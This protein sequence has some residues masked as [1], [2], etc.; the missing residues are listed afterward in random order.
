[1]LSV[2]DLF[3]AI[4]DYPE[5]SS[6]SYLDFDMFLRA[7]SHLKGDISP[8][9]HTVL[10]DT[11]PAV[12]PL[13]ITDFLADVAGI[14]IAAVGSLWD[15]VRE[16]VWTLPTPQEMRAREA[17]LFQRHGH[18]KGIVRHTLCPPVKQCINAECVSEQ[19]GK[20]F[21]KEEHRSVVIFTLSDGAHPAWVVQLKCRLCHTNYPHNYS[22]EDGA[23]HELSHKHSHKPL[24]KLPKLP[25]PRI[26]PGDEKLTYGTS[27]TVS[28]VPTFEDLRLKRELL[29]ALYGCGKSQRLLSIRAILP[30][31]QG[32]D[33][34]AQALAGTGKTSVLSI[35][36]L[37]SIDISVRETQALVLSPTRELATETQSLVL[38]LGV[39]MGVQCHACIGGTS[40]GEDIRK[41]GSG[42]HVVSGTPGRVFDMIR[43]GALPTQN[44][45]MLAL[46]GA[47]ELL[48][49]GTK[50]QILDVLCNLPPAIQVVSLSATFPHD[51][52][53]MT[54]KFM[55]NPIRISVK[56]DQ[57]V[58]EGV[59][60]FFVA[61]EKEELKFDTLCELYDTLTITQAVIFCNTWRKVDWLA[62]KMRAVDFTVSAL[63]CE[64]ALKERNALIAEFCGGTSRVLITD[65][66]SIRG[67]DLQQV[68]LAINYDLPANHENYIHRIGPLGIFGRRRVVINFMTVNDVRILHDIE[69]FYSTQVDEMPLNVADLI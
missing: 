46:D 42:Q 28:V 58:L 7:A 8:R 52:L 26:F 39:H 21:M 4:H 63:H 13:T 25:K 24:P 59:K 48:E 5:L 30:I 17:L 44:V 18:C 6:M 23:T 3:S 38:A 31:T 67:M 11:A 40:I 36:A 15:V 65:D 19:Y 43:R 27:E 61:V 56:S 45:K 29:R 50:D 14:S 22:V 53:E 69:Q 60:Q 55:N 54:T 41:L 33:V 62:E 66:S 1:M 57:S 49:R 35:S 32:R 9:P 37:Q 34:I 10:T 20:M 12:L 51:V 64:A 68:S 2:G 16:L 47:D